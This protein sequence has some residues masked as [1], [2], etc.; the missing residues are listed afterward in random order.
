MKQQTHMVSRGA[1]YQF[2]M[3]VPAELLGHYG[4]KSG[5]IRKSL[6]KDFPAAKAEAQRLAVHYGAEFD[7]ARR[8]LTAG[9]VPLT[10]DLLPGLAAALEAHILKA[11]EERRTQGL[12]EEQFATVEE[13]TAAE[14][15]R[16]R[17]AYAR[18]DSS[19]AGPPL[20]DWLRALGIQADPGSEVFALL[21]RRFVEGLLRARQGIAKRNAGEVVAAPAASTPEELRAIVVESSGPAGP[22][23][24][25][26]RPGKGPRLSE[27]VSYWKASGTK[28]PRSLQA[29]D[30]LVTEFTGMHGNLPLRQID[31][32]HFVALRD[33]MLKRVKP[34]TVQ[35]RFN[36]LRA[37][38]TVCI[39]DDQ[40]G[41][42]ASPMGGVKVRGVDTGEKTRYGFSGEQLQAVFSSPVFTQG[43]RPVGGRGE[44]A[45][46]GPLLALH[47]GAR[48]DELLC[49]R[50]DGVYEWEGVPVLHFRHRPELGQRLKGRAKNN[51]RVPVHP[52]LIR[53][54]FLDYAKSVQ[55]RG[56]WLFPDI[57]RTAKVRSH[58][59]A[60]G[61][62]FGRY[63][64]G[65]GI[66]DKRVTFH[67]FRHTFKDSARASSIPEDH[68]DAMTGHTTSEVARRYGSPE[69]YPV[70]ALA[71]SMGR[72]SFGGLDLLRGGR[73]AG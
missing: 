53:I 49:L 5:D 3:S 55:D 2:R 27:V 24:R 42:S 18:G 15:A 57:A 23:A 20:E 25:A 10:A 22:A 60:W 56:P 30:T 51:R 35:A 21:R 72:L 29:I 33:V 36:L 70:G 62:W 41:L 43:V 1:G 28:A 73:G 66:T 46:W 6:G 71:E 65:L 16:L 38:F 52:A 31:K 67:S 58:S 32:A 61:A 59:S 17:K 7:A 11:D 40:F 64:R 4:P 68:H 48:L 37:A 13:E 9:P 26:L 44:A 8:A 12:T 34:A 69:G 63:L 39:E 47:T 50:A 45:Y 14:L 19:P 54:G